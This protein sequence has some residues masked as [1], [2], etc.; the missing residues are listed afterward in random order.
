[1][2][3]KSVKQ[4]L[5]VSNCGLDHDPVE[6]FVRSEWQ[7]RTQSH[8]FLLYRWAAAAVAIASVIVALVQHIER[9]H[10]SVGTFFIYLTRWGILLNMTTTVYGAILVTLWDF[11]DDFKGVFASAHRFRQFRIASKQYL[12]T[13]L[14]SVF[15]AN[16]A[17]ASKMPAKFRVYWALHNIALTISLC[18]TIVYWAIL[19]N[20]NLD[21]HV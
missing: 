20:G 10:F 14:V 8:L 6:T 12:L 1:M 5:N 16:I 21:E 2:V 19:H 13:K 17:T 9:W 4:E 15:I 11:S 18:I 7:A 3:N